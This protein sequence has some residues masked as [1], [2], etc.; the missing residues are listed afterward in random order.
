MIRSSVRSIMRLVGFIVLF[1]SFQVPA[2][3]QQEARLQGIVVD[4]ATRQPVGSATVTLVGQD[5]AVEVGWRG[6]FDFPDAPMGL[7]LVR[8]DAP[9]RPSLTQ[10]VEV[11][12]ETIVFLEFL[13]PEISAFLS[14]FLVQGS[15]DK[16]EGTIENAAD[17]VVRKVPGAGSIDA[18]LGYDAPLKLRGSSTLSSAGEPLIFLDG[19]RLEGMGRALETLSQIPASDVTDVRVLRGPAAAFL[20]PLASNGV[21]LVETGIDRENK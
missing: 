13:V 11:S 1:L 15:P 18:E 6:T 17:L 10:E 9:G 14:E 2:H 12:L 21:I 5:L 20:Y 16:F 4:E 7:V 3:G 19:I 8:V